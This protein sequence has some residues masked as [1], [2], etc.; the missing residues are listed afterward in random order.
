[1][2]DGDLAAIIEIAVSE[3]LE[4]LEARRFGTTKRPRKTISQTNTSPRTRR[5]PAAVKR[6]VRDRDEGRCRYVDEQG[7]RC[8]AHVGVEYQH[9]RPFA[10]GG[11][12]SL[13]NLSLICH[14]HNRYL[15]EIDYG[16]EAMATYVRQKAEAADRSSAAGASRGWPLT[17]E[18][19]AR[20]P[21]R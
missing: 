5:V 4:R 1:V 2:P 16:R 13:T 11:D 20:R 15:A 19:T 10:L 17:P 8:T 12:H 14:G 3:K 18:N 6:A 21:L 9:R 7:R